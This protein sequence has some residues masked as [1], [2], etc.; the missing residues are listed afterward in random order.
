LLDVLGD[1]L[2]DPDDALPALDPDFAESPAVLPPDVDVLAEAEE[3]V[4]VD[5]LE[6][7]L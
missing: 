7:V 2:P 6:S 3:L 1:E 5:E 4:V